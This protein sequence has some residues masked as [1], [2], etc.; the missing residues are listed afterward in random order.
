[1]DTAHH[2][3]TDHYV[4]G[5]HAVNLKSPELGEAGDWHPECWSCPVQNIPWRSH[6][7]MTSDRGPYAEP[8]RLLA[9]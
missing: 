1:M 5:E 7:A 6:Y 3:G 2:R 9:Q 8:T 4:N